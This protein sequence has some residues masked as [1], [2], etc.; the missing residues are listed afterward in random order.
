MSAPA[1]WIPRSPDVLLDT[2]AQLDRFWADAERL[3]YAKPSL[4]DELAFLEQYHGVA[5]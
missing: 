4:A 5:E 3:G 2:A 1:P